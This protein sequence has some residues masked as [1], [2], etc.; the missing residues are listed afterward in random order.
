MPLRLTSP[1]LVASMQTGAAQLHAVVRLLGEGHVDA[2]LVE[3]GHGRHLVGGGIVLMVGRR[4]SLR[5]GPVD[6][7]SA[8]RLRAAGPAGRRARVPHRKGSKAYSQPLPAAKNPSGLPRTSPSAGELQLPC[9]M[10]GPMRKS[11]RATSLPVCLVEHDQR[12]GF[13]VRHVV[14]RPFDA[15][16]RADVEQVAVEQDRAVRRR[17]A[18]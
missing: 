18:A 8:A 7:R 4:R 5:G 2:V 6:A 13:G 1:V 16:G 15:L 17:C 11:S 9:V 14:V 10:S 3:H 12:R